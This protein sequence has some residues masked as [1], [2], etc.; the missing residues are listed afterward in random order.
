MIVRLIQDLKEVGK[1][2]EMVDVPDHVAQKLIAD[3]I[4][5]TKTA[6]QPMVPVVAPKPTKK[7][8]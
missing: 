4:A 5:E 6:V 1:K 7:P 3:E 8:D 2:G